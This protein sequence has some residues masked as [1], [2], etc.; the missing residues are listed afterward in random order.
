VLLGRQDS[1]LGRSPNTPAGARQAALI[2]LRGNNNED[3]AFMNGFYE[4][5]HIMRG[6]CAMC[7]ERVEQGAPLTC[8]EYCDGVWRITQRC[9]KGRNVWLGLIDE[10][11][12]MLSA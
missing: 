7:A 1:Q 8:L 9:D 11:S 10:C 12:H 2:C 6:G 3:S 4:R 5:T